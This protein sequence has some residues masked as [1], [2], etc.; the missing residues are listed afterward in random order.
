M[1]FF[2]YS[3]STGLPPFALHFSR[4]FFLF[5][6]QFIAVTVKFHAFCTLQPV[7]VIIGGDVGL[8]ERRSDVLRTKTVA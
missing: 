4:K 7:Q 6:P 8:S 2:R 1:I 5:R 3:T